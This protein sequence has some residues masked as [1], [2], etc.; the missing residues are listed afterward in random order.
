MCTR[1]KSVSRRNY[2]WWKEATFMRVILL[3]DPVLIWGPRVEMAVP[4]ADRI[5]VA[6]PEIAV[7]FLVPT[8]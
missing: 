5:S 1:K 3:K 8:L 2:S 6:E 4:K 7:R